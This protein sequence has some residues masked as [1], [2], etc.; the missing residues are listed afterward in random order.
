[1]AGGT[2]ER[3][4]GEERAVIH[5]LP[6]SASSNKPA[7][8]KMYTH[9]QSKSEGKENKE[10]RTREAA[11]TTSGKKKKTGKKTRRAPK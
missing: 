4:K 5:W 11:L 6:I 9:T 1:M 7:F 8:N 2:R 3:E 10:D